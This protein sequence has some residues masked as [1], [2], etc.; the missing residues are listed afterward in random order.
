M[1]ENDVLN[2]E[3]ICRKDQCSL[4]SQ[5]SDS[6]ADFPGGLVVKSLP[7]SEEMHIPSLGGED[8]LE[9]EMAT[10]SSIL[11]LGNREAWRAPFP[12]VAK[13]Q[14]RLQNQTTES[15]ALTLRD[16]IQPTQRYI[17]TKNSRIRMSVEKEMLGINIEMS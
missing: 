17:S 11:C 12:G 4:K 10:H 13:S 7:A 5:C 8:P 1:G 6:T 9:E 14:T 15:T 2:Q 16:T 3:V